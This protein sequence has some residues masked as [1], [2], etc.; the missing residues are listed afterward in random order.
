M[1]FLSDGSGMAAVMQKHTRD[2]NLGILSLTSCA[3]GLRRGCSIHEVRIRFAK[4]VQVGSVFLFFKHERD[5]IIIFI[6]TLLFC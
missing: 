2:K 5:K 6:L 1:P 4:S 3:Q